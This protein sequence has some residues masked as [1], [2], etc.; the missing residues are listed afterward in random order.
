MQLHYTIYIFLNSHVRQDY[1]HRLTSSNRHKPS[2]CQTNPNCSL[3]LSS[4]LIISAN[5]GQWE[6]CWLFL[7]LNQQGSYFRNCICIYRWHTH[8]L[9]R[10]MKLHMF[11]KA[12]LPPQKIQTALLWS[13]DLRHKPRFLNR[14][15]IWTIKI[16]YLHLSFYCQM[17][18]RSV[19]MPGRE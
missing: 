7:C 12:F 14:V 11:E 1:Q 10:H 2:I 8:L 6:G 3:G 15:N 17:I 9:L 4:P 5:H 18:Y 16:N 13:R 19:N